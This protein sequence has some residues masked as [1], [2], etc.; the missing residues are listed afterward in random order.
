MP[1]DR[2]RLATPIGPSRRPR[3]ADPRAANTSNL[4]ASHASAPRLDE[5][6]KEY[7]N[8][9]LECKSSSDPR[10]KNHDLA[11]ASIKA[12]IKENGLESQP[13]N[14]SVDATEIMAVAIPNFIGRLTVLAGKLM[15]EEKRSTLQLRDLRNA[16]ENLPTADFLVDVTDHFEPAFT[17]SSCPPADVRPLQHQSQAEWPRAAVTTLGGAP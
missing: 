16:T 17:S 13:R 2:N 14:I 11:H 8:V 12:V 9:L 6:T 7:L 15:E 1:L 3:M 4:A 5:Y 10:L